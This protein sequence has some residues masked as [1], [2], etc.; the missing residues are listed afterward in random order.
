MC[1]KSIVSDTCRKPGRWLGERST[2][3][4]LGS[5]CRLPS[6]DNSAATKFNLPRHNTSSFFIEVR[7]WLPRGFEILSSERRKWTITTVKN[8]IESE[9]NN[10]DPC[11]AS[12]SPEFSIVLLYSYQLVLS[13]G[14]AVLLLDCFMTSPWNWLLQHI[15]LPKYLWEYICSFNWQSQYMRKVG[16]ILQKLPSCDHNAIY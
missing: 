16:T 7:C 5:F 14:S 4:I 10:M 2:W 11:K 9:E 1:W 15:G 6:G 8:T 12:F 13:R 3:R